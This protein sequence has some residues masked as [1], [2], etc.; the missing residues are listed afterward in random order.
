[1][2]FDSSRKPHRVLLGIPGVHN[3]HVLYDD[4]AVPQSP[5]RVSVSEGCD[6]GRVVATG[7]G[8]E[9]GQADKINH[10]KIITR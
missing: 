9:Q 7:P 4:V 6:P 10:F 8:L 1:M 2:R 3:I 5:F